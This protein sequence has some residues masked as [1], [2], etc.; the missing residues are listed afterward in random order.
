[1][2]PALLTIYVPM[3]STGHWPLKRRWNGRSLR[4]SEMQGWEAF[5]MGQKSQLRKIRLTVNGK[6]YTFAVQP[7][8]TLMEV[9]REKLKLSKTKEGCAVGEC[10]S[11]AVIMDKKAVNACLVLAVDAKG[12]EILTA[13]GMAEDV[14]YHP[15]NEALLSQGAMRA[16]MEKPGSKPQQEFFTFCHICAGQVRRKGHRRGWQ[17]GRYRPRQGERSTE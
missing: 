5:D 1:M 6:A 13:E 11:C 4:L 3:P 15:F 14:E 9:L 10:G 8:D 7:W 12:S 16:S 17:G 2:K